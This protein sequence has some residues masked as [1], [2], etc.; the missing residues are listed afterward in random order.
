MSEHIN[1][2]GN[3]YDIIIVGGRPAGATLAARLGQAGLRVL[4][5][6]R[7][8][9]PSLPAASSPIIYPA[10]MQLLDEIGADEA[11]YA[12]NTPRIRRLVSE[13][14]EDFRVTF[15]LPAL[16]GRDYLYA[17]DRARFDAALW[18]TAARQPTV[19]THDG[20][21]VTDVL[22]DGKRIVG[23]TGR[24]NGRDTQFTANGV[25]GADGRFSL[26][27]RK[28][29]A[30]SYDEQ[31]D[32]PTSIYYAYWKQVQPYASGAPIVH[33]YATGRGYGFG[34]M[35]SAD[36][37]TCVVIEGRA[38]ALEL[39]DAKAH[40]L[41]LQLLQQHPRVWR[42]LVGAEQLTDVRG[43][44]NIGNMY[45]TAGGPGWALVGDALHQ[46]DPIDGQGIYDAVVTAK[47]L[48]QALVAWRNGSITW[49][50]ALH[51]YTAAVRAETAPMYAVTM[52]RVKRELYTEHPAWAY[53]S[54]LRW[55]VTDPE[56][57]RRMVWLLSRGLPAE[58]WLPRTVFFKA[59]VRG[60]VRDV[61]RRLARMPEP[62]A[63]PPLAV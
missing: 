38:N 46:K 40:E 29:G 21:S 58:G 12:H 24:A 32:M 60:A 49:E 20:F 53:R 37:T 1:T 4:L 34:L 16:F 39:G 42:R 47:L 17:I 57:G 62:Y 8:V 56:Y 15:D 25:V 36:G 50:Q 11:E 19:I 26:V 23:I 14:R 10:T 18:R 31:S 7:A 22:R 3:H 30:A 43:M 51:Q 44:R 52:D 63:L 48:A 61:A 35:D 5:L 41:Y 2:A 13:V 27:A 54:W 6:E 9:M 33:S 45:R 59:L 55:L 28:A